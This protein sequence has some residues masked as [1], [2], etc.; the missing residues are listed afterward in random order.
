[1]TRPHQN[2]VALPAPDQL[3]PPQYEG[4]HEDLAQFSILRDKRAQSITSQ[5]QEF[6]R[7]CGPT[8]DKAAVP[9]DHGHLTRKLTRAVSYNGALASEIRLHNFHPSRK[10][11]KKGD[12]RVTRRK[13]DFACLHLSD[14]AHR[15]NAVDLRC[16]QNW[17]GLRAG[18]EHAGY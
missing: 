9:G 11:D 17:K 3:K 15:Q 14:F 4:P 1:V 8:E 6:A 10:Q 13:Q 12:I 16:G 2:E 5:F 7:F 18:I